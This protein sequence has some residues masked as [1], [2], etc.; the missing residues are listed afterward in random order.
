[1]KFPRSRLGLVFSSCYLIGATVFIIESACTPADWILCGRLLGTLIVALPWT[2][3]FL[4]NEGEL[5]TM[6]AVS[7][8]GIAINAAILYLCGY[9][10]GRLWKAQKLFGP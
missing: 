5:D 4:N 6:I 3:P 8:I 9:A 7:G 2:Y 10:V 1:M